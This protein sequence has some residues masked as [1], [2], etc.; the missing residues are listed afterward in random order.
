MSQFEQDSLQLTD[1]PVNLYRDRSTRC[2]ACG[3]EQRFDPEWFVRWECQGE[4]CPGCGVDCTEEKATRV[5]CEPDDP[6]PDDSLVPKLSWWHTSTYEDWPSP[7]FNPAARLTDL[8]RQRM[9]EPMI[10]RWVGSQRAKALHVGT[11]ESAIHNMLR[12]MRDQ[13]EAGRRFFLYRV[14]LRADVT[15]LG[16]CHEEPGDWL[17]DVPLTKVCP[18]ELDVFRYENQHED[19][20]SISLALGRGAIQSVQQ[21]ALPVAAVERPAWWTDAVDRMSVASQTLPAPG[22]PVGPL[23]QLRRPGWA[24]SSP[25]A[26]VQNDLRMELT[27]HLPGT[28]RGAAEASIRVDATLAPTEWCRLA[29]VVLQT[30]R[31]PAKVMQAARA[32][33]PRGVSPGSH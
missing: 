5:I 19:K 27:S 11:Y 25:V 9:G 2:A 15:I 12:R 30:L 17:G 6:A 16:G 29:A 21:L 3:H 14:Q 8:A 20:G 26:E 7:D 1:R 31:D 28:L 18:S 4:V 13:P 33:T 24:V 32:S 10:A 22:T 23:A